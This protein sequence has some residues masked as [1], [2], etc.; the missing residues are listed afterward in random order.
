MQTKAFA[1]R[2]SMSMIHIREATI[3]D[4][5]V[6]LHHRV[7]MVTS[8]GW[9]DEQIAATREATLKF[10]QE[11]WNPN[12]SCYLAIEDSKVIGSCAVSFGI[13]FPTYNNPSGRYAYLFNM[14]VEPRR[15]GRGVARLLLTHITQVCREKGID[16]MTLH[17]TKMS[18]GL[19]ERDGF[20]KSEN[21]F[22][23]IIT[24]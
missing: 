14:F 10:L 8:M 24:D 22:I 19:Y 21:Y 3:E 15:R 17:D 11:P 4:I 20:V 2:R 12:I 23:K 16:K 9:S 6:I 7:G 1:L 13:A 18:R 5:P